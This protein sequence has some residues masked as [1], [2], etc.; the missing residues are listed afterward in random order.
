MP[1]IDANISASITITLRRQHLKS[2]LLPTVY[3]DEWGV[4]P[5][6]SAKRISPTVP[7]T[8]VLKYDVMY[9]CRNDRRTILVNGANAGLFRLFCAQHVVDEVVEHADKWTAGTGITRQ[10]FLSRWLTE[11]L[12]LIR[13]VAEDG[14][15]RRLLDPTETARLTQ[16]ELVDPDDL[17]SARLALLLEAF[18]L[19]EDQPAWE[20]VYGKTARAEELRKW[21]DT[22]SAGAY[23][24][25]LEQAIESMSLIPAMASAGI[26]GAG[27]C[28]FDKIGWPGLVL[29]TVLG[30]VGWR[31]VKPETRPSLGSMITTGLEGRLS[32][33]GEY[34]RLLETFAAAVPDVPSW[35]SLSETNKSSAVLVRGCLRSLAREPEGHCS[36]AE[37]ASKLPRLSVAQGEAKVRAS[38]RAHP[39]FDQVWPGRW[40]VGSVSPVFR[41]Y[42]E[43][44]SVAHPEVLREHQP[45]PV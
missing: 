44:L 11:C 30:Y 27:K 5:A 24:G 23:A 17:A 32:L 39:C 26:Y 45:D 14:I 21:L 7:D 3:P 37:L 36:A 13:V 41:P 22:L 12:P 33:F 8:N 29:I 19:T 9:A 16:L 42:L 28:V 18:Y 35:A 1:S 40:H 25:E 2:A 20:A 4:F 10:Q 15:L 6:S 43:H 34:Q 38:L 31:R